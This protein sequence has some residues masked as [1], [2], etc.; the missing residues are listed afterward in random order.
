MKSDCKSIYS[1]TL[2]KNKFF[3]LYRMSTIII[4]EKK[5]QHSGKNATKKIKNFKTKVHEIAKLPIL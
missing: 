4:T 3:F 1:K 5:D 2:S